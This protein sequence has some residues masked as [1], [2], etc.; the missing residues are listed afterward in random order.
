MK[1][2]DSFVPTPM[3]MQMDGKVRRDGKVKGEKFI[4][5]SLFWYGGRIEKVIGIK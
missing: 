2:R 4:F 5:F 3:F 1:Q